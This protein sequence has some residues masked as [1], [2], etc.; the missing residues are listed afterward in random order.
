MIRVVHYVNQFFGQIAGREK[1]G[2]GPRIVEGAVGPG[3]LIDKLLAGRGKVT[4]TVICGDDYFAED[5]ERVASEITDLIVGQRPQMFIAGPAFNA[6][7]YGLA[8][9]K[10]C[11]TVQERLSIPAVAGMFPENPGVGLYRRHVL[12]VETGRTAS[13]M[14]KAMPKMV[15]L[16]RRLLS[17]KR[18]GPASDEGYMPRLVKENVITDKLA[19]ERAIDYLLKKIRGEPV[20]SEISLSR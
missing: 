7:P 2:I 12:I 3:V 4:A 6:G 16:S 17:G 18:L 11:K 14:A 9:G 15:K 8:C 20:E 13:A 10:M 19:A 5:P 1:G